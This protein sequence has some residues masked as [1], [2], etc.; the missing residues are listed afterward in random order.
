MIK[1]V[2]QNMS[3]K[4]IKMEN[5]FIQLTSTGSRHL[6]ETGGLGTLVPNHSQKSVEWGAIQL[7]ST[8]SRHPKVTGGLGT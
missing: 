6:K 5:L 3:T 2:I 7:T 8:G 1:R 4:H